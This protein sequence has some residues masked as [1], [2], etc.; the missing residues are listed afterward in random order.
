MNVPPLSC[1]MGNH[2]W[3]PWSLRPPTIGQRVPYLYWQRECGVKACHVPQRRWFAVEV[4][5]WLTIRKPMPVERL[6]QRLKMT[7]PDPE[8]PELIESS[9]PPGG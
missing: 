1:L 9:T 4:P 2:Q 5:V 7:A 8:S 3:G 6:L